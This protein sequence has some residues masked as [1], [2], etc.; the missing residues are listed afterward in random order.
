[1]GIL[2]KEELVND[3]LL[4]TKL[5]IPLERPDLVPRQHLLGRL[6]AG[7]ACK[8]I[9]VSAPAGFGKTTLVS[10]WARASGIPLAWLS[11]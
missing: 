10:T 3:L 5:R 9:L 11:L 4:A 2:G 6:N 7:L 8:M 1:M